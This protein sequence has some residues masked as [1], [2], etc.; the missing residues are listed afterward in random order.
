M[1]I[2]R[3]IVDGFLTKE[4]NRDLD[5]GLDNIP[6]VIRK[7]LALNKGVFTECK[8]VH[9]YEFVKGEL[10]NSG[11]M[12][13]CIS[14]WEL[15]LGRS[16]WDEL[17]ES[18]R[19]SGY[20]KASKLVKNLSINK[21]VD[22]VKKVEKKSVGTIE[23][24]ISSGL[25]YED[26]SGYKL[27]Y[28]SD[29]NDKLLSDKL[30][31]DVWKIY[32]S[33][34]LIVF[35]PK[36]KYEFSMN[37]EFYINDK[38]YKRVMKLKVEKDFSLEENLR[39]VIIPFICLNYMN[40]LKENK[41]EFEEGLLQDGFHTDS[42]FSNISQLANNI[43]I[44]RGF[45]DKKSFLGVINKYAILD[46]LMPKLELGTDIISTVYTFTD[47]HSVATEV[48]DRDYFL[49]YLLSVDEGIV[50]ILS[51]MM[52]FK[53]HEYDLYGYY[54]KTG[55]SSALEMFLYNLNNINKFEGYSLPE[56]YVSN[57]KIVEFLKSNRHG[58]KLLLK[59]IS[60]GTP[61]LDEFF[62]KS[63]SISSAY[64]Y[65]RKVYPGE[66]NEKFEKLFDSNLELLKDDNNKFV[67]VKYLFD[68]IGYP[69]KK[70]NL[71]LKD[72]GVYSRKFINYI[73]KQ[74]IGNK[75]L[76]EMAMVDIDGA[77]VYNSQ[78]N[79]NKRNSKIDTLIKDITVGDNIQMSTINKIVL[80]IKDTHSIEEIKNNT[81]NLRNDIWNDVIHELST[82]YNYEHFVIRQELTQDQIDIIKMY[83]PNYI[84]YIIK[85]FPNESNVELEKMIM[86]YVPLNHIDEN[87]FFSELK[88]YIKQFTKLNSEFETFL[89]NKYN[90]IYIDWLGDRPI[91]GEMVKV[92]K[93]PNMFKKW[94]KDIPS[95][96]ISL[97][98][99]K[100][101]LNS[102]GCD[103]GTIE[104]IVSSLEKYGY[105]KGTI[106]GKDGRPKKAVDMRAVQDEELHTVIWRSQTYLN[107]SKATPYA[108]TQFMR[109]SLY[110]SD[111]NNKPNDGILI[112]FGLSDEDEKFLIEKHP[113][114][115]NV[116]VNARTGIHPNKIKNSFGWSRIDKLNDKVWLIEEIQNDLIKIY[117][118]ETIRR[119]YTLPDGSID[120]DTYEVDVKVLQNL[121]LN[122]FAQKAVTIIKRE[123]EKNGVTT[124][125]WST[126]RQKKDIGST[127]PPASLGYDVAP[128]EMGFELSDLPPEL[129]F[130]K[131]VQIPEDKDIE[132]KK[133]EG[134]KPPINPF[135][136]PEREA[137]LAK[138]PKEEREKEKRSDKDKYDEILK[139]WRRENRMK[140]HYGGDMKRSPIYKNSPSL[141]KIWKADINQIL[142]ESYD[143]NEMVK[144][145][146]KIFFS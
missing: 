104:K 101:I 126:Y 111:P 110:N 137:E 7:S 29:K 135:T 49:K 125:Y 64:E 130:V 14:Y 99:F 32:F 133:D 115:H 120:H 60:S 122:N 31:D 13:V 61:E 53:P 48:N 59:S 84:E 51:G 141:D 75:D 83:V 129:S 6:N 132:D 87:N 128:R 72:Y 35:N 119:F 25:P 95:E 77:L 12:G 34:S 138:L 67:M 2:E 145:L 139:V 127:T 78:F 79:N 24:M 123:A 94:L 15:V 36:D 1:S 30:G 90:S 76:E 40:K 85:K 108:T 63:D 8:K 45:F 43:L 56:K 98:E 50:A 142:D 88:K 146:K 92:S 58:V 28:H 140:P 124:L 41:L 9:D 86:S 68:D 39:V 80:Y 91:E 107:G 37:P 21:E 113:K 33:N 89:K 4:E 42:A 109:K 93:S 143:G 55:E 136:T 103:N 22:V 18:L 26:E 100:K 117:K 23:E 17:V 10:I 97:E 5:D 69:L 20:E 105:M 114:L 66:R 38:D 116:I 74:N 82:V 19:D 47:E 57:K 81:H 112:M 118:P 73:T 96:L 62:I 65:I 134:N 54:L 71:L 102:K 131:N 3:R 44:S 70:Y 11:M 52:Y 16:R 46:K 144:N 121:L 27:Y 106:V